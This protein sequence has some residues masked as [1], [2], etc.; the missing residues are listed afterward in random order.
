MTPTA[1]TKNATSATTATTTPTLCPDTYTIQESDDC[2]KISIAQ[3]VSTFSLLYQ[4]DLQLYC[5]DFPDP[6]KSLCLSK[7]CDIYTVRENDT[8][9]SI[10]QS[11]PSYIT[12][13]QLLSWN[14]N[15]NLKCSNIDQQVGFQ[16]CIR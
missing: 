16:I 12:I 8:C 10:A 14:V 3:N 13:T 4:N 1:L 5:K 7:Q 11:Q 6:E 15:L 9:Y 2:N